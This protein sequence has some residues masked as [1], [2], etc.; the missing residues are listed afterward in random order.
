MWLRCS[1]R[2]RWRLAVTTYILFYSFR[3]SCCDDGIMNVCA[4]ACANVCTSILRSVT[5]ASRLSVRSSRSLEESS[6]GT[7]ASSSI[8]H[9][10]P[11][12]TKAPELN[13]GPCV[14]RLIV[15]NPLPDKIGQNK[16]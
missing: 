8:I 11:L 10:L 15:G 3:Q 4:C 7:N 12:S 2:S 6:S 9:V 16:C 5:F 13:L 14:F 1:S